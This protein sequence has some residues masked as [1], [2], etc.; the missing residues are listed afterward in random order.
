MA[1]IDTIRPA[2]SVA[3]PWLAGAIIL[4]T[5]A[6]NAFLSFLNGHVFPTSASVVM[7][8]E[9]L[10]LLAAGLACRRYLTLSHVYIIALIAGYA[11]ALAA[12]RSIA[13]PDTTFD[14]KSA[15]DLVIPVIFFLLGCAVADIRAADKIVGVVT[16]VL[17][18]F[19]LFESFAL[20]AY[21]ETFKVAE[22]YIA[23]GTLEANAHSLNVSGGL[24]VSGMRPEEQGRTLLPFLSG[25]RISS[26][27]L[28]PSTLGNYG[29]IVALWGALR[30]RITSRFFLWT[31]LGGLVLIVLSDTRMAALL[32]VVGF[33]VLMMPPRLT[34]PAA[35]ALPFVTI[36][37]LCLLAAWETPARGVAEVEGLGLYDR[38]LYSGRVLISFDIFNWFGLS[39]SKAQTFDSG[40]GYVISNLGI[41]G[42]AVLWAVFMS[43]KGRN[44]YFYAFRNVSAVFFAI[45]LCISAS[46]FTIKLA[47]T[48][49]FL[50]GILSVTDAG[51]IAR[52]PV[53]THIPPETPRY[54][55]LGWVKPQAETAPQWL[56]GN[57]NRPA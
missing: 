7:A 17:L 36:V 29:A 35:F 15:R 16:V 57:P 52:R 13:T 28:E 6:F 2:T 38:L 25:H 26:L 37:A 32:A 54:A 18:G 31:I 50:L 4:G 8:S 1:N 41:I 47:A 42:F 3:S 27:F 23:R 30:S 21:L 20:D 44:E 9:A 53:R 45:L 55:R 39:V 12:A 56:T 40:Y 5:V 11:L 49:W 22:Y 24:M 48:W 51:A 43:L 10:L 14:P 19:G 46:M 34:T 33:I